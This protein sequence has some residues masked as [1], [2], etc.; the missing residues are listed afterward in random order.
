VTSPT[1]TPSG[2]AT[3]SPP[4]ASVRQ[5]APSTA[6]AAGA[7]LLRTPPLPRGARRSA[8]ALAS[9]VFAAVAPLAYVVQRV[10]EKLSGHGQDP[11]LLV[12]EL[13][14]AFYWRA[15]IATW[16]GGLALAVAVALLTR[17]GAVRWHGA[18]AAALGVV[19]PAVLVL[20]AVASWVWP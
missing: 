9:L 16:W 8:W 12:F 13:R 15:T 17:P 2:A 6:V 4:P 14:T 3:P 19:V 11:L 1:T 7:G 20:G 5:G 10:A 18:V